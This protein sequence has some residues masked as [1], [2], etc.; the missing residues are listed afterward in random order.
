M[1]R[2]LYSMIALFVPVSAAFGAGTVTLSL[3]S[4]S[5]G[6]YV[7]A[8]STVQWTITA[9]VSSGDNL[10]LAM[11]AVDFTQDAA[12][13]VL[14]DIPAAQGVPAAMACFDRSAGISNPI[15]PGMA[16]GY[17]GTPVGT[18]GEKNLAQIGGAQNVFGG[19]VRRRRV[20]R[21]CASGDWPGVGGAGSS[22]R[23]FYGSLHARAV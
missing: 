23:V 5:N 7:P 13:A 12:N 21:L 20:R 18:L 22:Q 6:T 8:G 4:P 16:S 17:C 11:I 3:T 15:G 9:T 2:P 10:G 19:G 14:F 1:S